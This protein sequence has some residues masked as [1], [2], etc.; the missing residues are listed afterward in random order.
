[1]L[2]VPLVLFQWFPITGKTLP[3]ERILI[4]QVVIKGQV[5]AP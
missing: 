1:M 2:N 3:L 5:M 4:R